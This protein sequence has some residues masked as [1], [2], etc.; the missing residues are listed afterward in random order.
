MLNAL[1]AG[2]IVNVT[3]QKSVLLGQSLGPK[4]AQPEP[5]IQPCE[6]VQ[7]SGQIRKCNGCEELFDKNNEQLLI[8]GSSGFDWYISVDGK[9][10]TKVY[11]I[12]QC[13]FY[14]CVKRRCLLSRRPLVDVKSIDIKTDLELSYDEK[15]AIE[16]ELGVNL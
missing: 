4:P 14:Y 16:N 12:N 2:K 5:Q 7:R 3:P 9:N 13:N 8:L 15:D 11:N 10:N 1:K 6:T